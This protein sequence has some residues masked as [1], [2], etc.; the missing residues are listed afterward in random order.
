MLL[1][2]EAVIMNHEEEKS[3]ENYAFI[4]LKQRKNLLSGTF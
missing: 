2:S 1:T 3:E 4:G